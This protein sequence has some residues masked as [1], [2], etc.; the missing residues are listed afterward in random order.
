MVITFPRERETP[1]CGVSGDAGASSLSFPAPSSAGAA[2][3]GAS[4]RSS[5]STGTPN[6]RLSSIRLSIVGTAWSAS[7]L[8]TACRERPSFS[9]SASWLSLWSRRRAAIFSPVVIVL[10]SC[11][12]TL[13]ENPLFR[14]QPCVSLCQ[15]QVAAR[16]TVAKEPRIRRF[17]ALFRQYRRSFNCAVLPWDW[18]TEKISRR[19]TGR[20]WP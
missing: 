20:G 1:L 14:H 10:T 3:K 12:L 13:S 16:K 8:L 15:P 18:G 11:K 2:G 17:E 9:P 4:G 6:S 19:R 5:V 7:H